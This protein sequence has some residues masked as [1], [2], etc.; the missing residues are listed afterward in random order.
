[1]AKKVVK[2]VEDF[3]FGKEN[4]IIMLTGLAVIFLGFAMMTGG[5]S[6][7][8]KIWNPEIF[9]WRR[10][11]LAPILVISGFVIEVYAILKK[12]KE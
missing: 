2:T 8:P 4:F 9:S 12:S 6:E 3:P 5:G 10:I 1:M 11:T 7:D